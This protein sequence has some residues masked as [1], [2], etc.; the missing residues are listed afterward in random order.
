MHHIGLQK[1]VSYLNTINKGY[2]YVQS[3][4][5]LGTSSSPKAVNVALICHLLHLKMPTR[6]SAYYVCLAYFY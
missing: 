2:P 5:S 4:N 6:L 1:Y 3:V